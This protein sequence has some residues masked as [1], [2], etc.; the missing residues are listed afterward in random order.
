MGRKEK[1]YANPRLAKEESEM[2]NE[3]PLPQPLT[4]VNLP[5]V[6]GIDSLSDLEWLRSSPDGKP[7][8]AMIN[9]LDATP[10]AVTLIAQPLRK[11]VKIM[12]ED[13]TCDSCGETCSGMIT[14][15]NGIE[16]FEADEIED[17][18]AG[19]KDELKPFQH[20]APLTI[21]VFLAHVHADAKYWLSV[22]RAGPNS[23]QPNA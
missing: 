23:P 21:E 12:L 8:M 6:A 14:N 11:L 13:Q 2:A 5:W 4:F 22:E 16:V 1:N 7:R 10:E 3:T 20:V 18:I 17:Y 9:A 19:A 15:I